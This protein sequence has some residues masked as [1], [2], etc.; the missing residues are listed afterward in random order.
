MLY[1]MCV[2]VFVMRS[3]RMALE[4]KGELLLRGAFRKIAYDQYYFG[5]VS[6]TARKSFIPFDCSEL[7]S[8]IESTIY[9]ASQSYTVVGLTCDLNQLT[10]VLREKVKLPFS[11]PI[12]QDVRPQVFS[13]TKGGVQRIGPS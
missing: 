4:H 3:S 1:M 5:E 2:D 8:N 12:F 11:P 6:E 13:Y 9:A 10:L 7:R